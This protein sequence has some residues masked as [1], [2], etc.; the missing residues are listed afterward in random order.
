MVQQ[1]PHLMVDVAFGSAL[2][3]GMAGTTRRITTSLDWCGSVWRA[4][5]KPFALLALGVLG[6]AIALTVYFPGA[7]TL[8][9]A[10]ALWRT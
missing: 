6:C 9:E 8:G 7:R 5:W 4:T 1:A 2:A 3:S 10:L